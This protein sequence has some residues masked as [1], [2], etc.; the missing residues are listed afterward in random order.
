MELRHLRYFAALAEELHF[1]RAAEKSFVAQPTL[2]QQI[3]TFEEELGVR[4]FERTKRSVELTQAGE[5]LL[6]YA[7]RILKDAKRA[8]KAAHAAREGEAGYLRIGFE[9][10]VMRSGLSRVIKTFQEE[11]PDVELELE[12]LGSRAQADALRK[13]S[14]DVGFVLLPIDERDLLAL[15]IDTAQ[16]IAVLPETHR[17]AGQ[18][19]VAI[20]ELESEPHIMWA[21]DIAPG[22]YDNYLRECHNAGFAPEVVQEIRHMESLLGLV[23]AGI[24]ISTAHSARAESGYPGVT[25]ALITEPRLPIRM[26]VAWPQGDTLPVAERFLEVVR[27]FAQPSDE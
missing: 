14:L 16:T 2:S 10:S 8:E 26:G 18:E 1:G 13:E 19:H 17:L 6:P 24:G 27:R 21:R 23:A 5:A 9:G 4:L 22:V 12:E 7:R 3:Q 25:Y 20:G 15:E 11:V